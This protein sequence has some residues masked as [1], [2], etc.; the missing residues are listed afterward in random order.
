[1]KQTRREILPPAL[2]AGV[3]T[4]LPIGGAAAVPGAVA[5]AKPT[6]R[7]GVSTYAYWHGD[8]GKDPRETVIEMA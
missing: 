2:G 8:T 1:M 4:A 6:V 3:M 7:I 5:E